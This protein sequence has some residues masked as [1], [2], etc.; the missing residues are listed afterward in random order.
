[1]GRPELERRRGESVELRTARKPW[2]RSG[3]LPP[4]SFLRSVDVAVCTARTPPAVPATRSDIP[5]ACVTA[6]VNTNG[7]HGRRREDEQKSRDANLSQLCANGSR[8]VRRLLAGVTD[9]HQIPS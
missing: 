7:S 4:P 2:W 8:I 5:A 1:M 6:C 9:L 3:P